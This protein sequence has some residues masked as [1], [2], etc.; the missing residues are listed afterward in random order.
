MDCSYLIFIHRIFKV[1]TV[2]AMKGRL[3]LFCGFSINTTPLVLMVQTGSG[4]TPGTN[5][6]SLCI[7]MEMCDLTMKTVCRERCSKWEKRFSA[8]F[9]FSKNGRV[10]SVVHLLHVFCLLVGMKLQNKKV[11]CIRH[12]TVCTMSSSIRWLVDRPSKAKSNDM[13]WLSNQ[14]LVSCGCNL[15]CWKQELWHKLPHPHGRRTIWTKATMRTGW[16]DSSEAGVYGW[17][18]SY[19]TLFLEGAAYAL[20]CYSFRFYME[21]IFTHR[22]PSSSPSPTHT[23]V[24]TAGV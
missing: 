7:V 23:H 20:C 16:R 11:S 22:S 12:V 14:P 2:E 3:R 6:T 18:A 19:L 15:A 5:R 9:I 4:N 10:W 13:W 1:E 8:D 17:K 21:K 24:P